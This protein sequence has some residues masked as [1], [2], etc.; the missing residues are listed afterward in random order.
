MKRP[1]SG[2]NG[3]NTGK[4]SQLVKRDSREMTFSSCISVIYSNREKS[5]HCCMGADFFSHSPQTAVFSSRH[6]CCGRRIFLKAG[7]KLGAAR[8][9]SSDEGSQDRMV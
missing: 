6:T 8:A 1:R 7:K 3:G 2:R 9:W 5:R 4:L